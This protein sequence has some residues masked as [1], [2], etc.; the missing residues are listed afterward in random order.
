MT[1]RYLISSSGYEQYFSGSI[2]LL[3]F[4]P[5]G[6]SR[7]CRLEPWNTTEGGVCLLQLAAPLGLRPPFA[8]LLSSLPRRQEEELLF[9]L[10]Q[11]VQNIQKEAGAHRWALSPPPCCPLKGQF[12]GTVNLVQVKL[13]GTKVFNHIPA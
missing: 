8:R 2:N 11:K 4:P 5:L 10:R 1:R 12:C 3:F 6:V 7:R 13:S 9:P